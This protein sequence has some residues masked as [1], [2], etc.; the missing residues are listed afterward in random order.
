MPVIVPV[1]ATS[2]ATGQV[3]RFASVTAAARDG[4][5]D[6]T[7][8]SNCVNGYRKS[9]NGFT[10]KADCKLRPTGSDTLIH[11]IAALRNTGHNTTEI[12]AIMGLSASTVRNRVPMARNI[13]LL[14][15]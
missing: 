6:R 14:T 4:G 9:H 3:V 8:V 1:I 2:I 13:G 11:K 7:C 10:F 5:F 12:A 15:K